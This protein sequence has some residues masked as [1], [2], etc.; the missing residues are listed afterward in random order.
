MNFRG[1][2]MYVYV[3]RSIDRFFSDTFRSTNNPQCGKCRNILSHFFLQKFRENIVFTFRIPRKEITK[4]EI[5]PKQNIFSVRVNY[6]FFH[7]VCVRASHKSL[8]P[9]VMIIRAKFEPKK[10][11]HNFANTLGFFLLSR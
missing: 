1:C 6:S 10:L 8:N 2:L 9:I 5:L 4:V 11:C 3:G 7:T